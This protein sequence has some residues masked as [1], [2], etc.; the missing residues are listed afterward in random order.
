MSEGVEESRPILSAVSSSA[1]QIFALLR[2]VSFG[3]KF[4][5]QPTEEG[6]RFSVEESSVMEGKQNARRRQQSADK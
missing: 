4:M 5:V 6:I 3:S 1:R 2:C